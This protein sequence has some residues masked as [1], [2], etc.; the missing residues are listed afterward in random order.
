MTIWEAASSPASQQFLIW[1]AL[2]IIPVILAY[3]CYTYWVFRGPVS[4]KD[5]YGHDG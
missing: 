4:D 5:G 3:T 2:F 1:G